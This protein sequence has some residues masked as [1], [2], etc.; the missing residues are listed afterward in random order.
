MKILIADESR[1]ISERTAFILQSINAAEIAGLAET[2]SETTRIL[3][4][5]E[6]DILITE[7]KFSDG[8]GFR[9]IEQARSCYPK[10]LIVVFSDHH[11]DQFRKKA[12]EAGASYFF[13]KV[14]ELKELLITITILIQE[15]DHEKNTIHLG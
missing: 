3:R 2:V 12:I 8:D 10:L 14:K 13:N 11:E 9:V 1:L 5:A 15:W 6:P 4:K 7:L